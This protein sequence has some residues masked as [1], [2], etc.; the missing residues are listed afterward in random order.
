MNPGS[1]EFNV[2][3]VKFEAVWSSLYFGSVST[4]HYILYKLTPMKHI[5]MCKI[6]NFCSNNFKLGPAAPP[7]KNDSLAMSA[8]SFP[9]DFWLIIIT[10]FVYLFLGSE[11]I[12]ALFLKV[13]NRNSIYSSIS[14]VYYFTTGILAR[15]LYKIRE[16]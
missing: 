2:W 15:N 4:Q 11:K 16:S 13:K 14:I 3:P 12:F 9:P 5:W 8:Q 6:T 1:S 10:I 7:I